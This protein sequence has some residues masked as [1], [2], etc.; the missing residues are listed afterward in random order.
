MITEDIIKK[1]FMTHILTEEAVKIKNLQDEAVREFGLE[2]TL[3]TY[4]SYLKGHFS[5]NASDNSCRLT[6]RYVKNIR[7]I[8]ISLSRKKG[9][10]IYNRIVFGRIYRYTLNKLR[11]GFVDSIKESLKNE[12][13]KAGY[14]VSNNF[15][16]NYYQQWH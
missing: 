12:L 11:F 6:L 3:G 15:I 13:Q 9:L 1:G 16:D 8:D 14:T 4:R 10:S 2:E 7:Y 5:V